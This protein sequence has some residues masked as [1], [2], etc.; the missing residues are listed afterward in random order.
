VPHEG[1]V[2]LEVRYVASGA[3][4]SS[5]YD[6]RIATTQQHAVT[7]IYY[8][9]VRQV[10]PILANDICCEQRYLCS[11]TAKLKVQLCRSLQQLLVHS[12]TLLAVFMLVIQHITKRML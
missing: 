10:T 3:S 11:N 7:C 9:E 8:G 12:V 2:E 5:S 4:W 6:V 1:S